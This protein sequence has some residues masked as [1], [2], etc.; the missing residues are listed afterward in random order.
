MDLVKNS[1]KEAYKKFGKSKE[2]L[3]LPKG[4]QKERFSL[5]TQ[6]IKKDNFSVLDF[7]CGFG[8]L[9]KYLMSKFDN[10]EY[11]GVDIVEEFIAE[12]KKEDEKSFILIESE[13]DIPN[14][15]FDYICIS[16]TF[17]RS[18]FDDL[19]KHEAK[20][21]DILIYLFNN[22]L[23]SDGILSVD[24]L[25]D[26]V[27]YVEKGAYHINIPKIY[28]FITNNLS[29]RFVINKHIF[30]FEVTFNIFKNANMNEIYLYKDYDLFL[31]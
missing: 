14:K 6:F 21:Q 10:F 30:C 18:Y 28:E 23:K 24:F 1:Y 2:T 31:S 7:G 12:N 25:H 27:N 13:K 29:K 9:R 26:E 3:G 5:L 8:D 16:G 15:E 20:V 19:N 17:N 22:H 4:R 11:L